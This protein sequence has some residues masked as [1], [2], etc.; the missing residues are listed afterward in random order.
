MVYNKIIHHLETVTGTGEV[1]RYRA[2]CGSTGR[3]LSVNIQA[4]TCPVCVKIL[5]ETL[6]AIWNDTQERT[7]EE[8]EAEIIRQAQIIKDTYGVK[9]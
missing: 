2:R 4:V 7:I 1:P 5:D 3:R 6:K 9:L 8:T